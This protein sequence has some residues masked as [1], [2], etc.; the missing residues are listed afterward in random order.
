MSDK[1]ERSASEVLLSIEEEIKWLSAWARSTDLVIKMMSN[2][3]KLLNHVGAK[4]T[5]QV[6]PA[7]PIPTAKVPA[8]IERPNP[9]HA[10]TVSTSVEKKPV[11]VQQRIVYSQD[12]RP[13]ILADVKVFS[14]E[15]GTLMKHTR[16]NASGF[17]DAK[18]PMGLYKIEVKKGPN[19]NKKGFLKKYEVVVTENG[20]A[21][22]LERKAV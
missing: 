2:E 6:L 13:V 11:T 15:S 16:T 19:A 8:V 20:G 18:I 17:W 9:A 14:I 22:E 1:K 7:P 5:P 12:Q 3:L 4:P 21:Q 10:P